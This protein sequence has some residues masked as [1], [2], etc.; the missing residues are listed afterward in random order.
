MS[1][2]H[3]ETAFPQHFVERE[4]GGRSLRTYLAGQALAGLAANPAVLTNA[5]HLVRLDPK[6][7]DLEAAGIWAKMAVEF[8]DA[9]L[10]ELGKEKT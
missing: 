6:M 4:Y 10:A 1:I 5:A 2:E 9:L 7:T 3:T 8:A